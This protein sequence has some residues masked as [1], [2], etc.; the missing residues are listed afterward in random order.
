MIQPMIIHFMAKTS[1]GEYFHV[2]GSVD[3]E[4]DIEH[5]IRKLTQSVSS[6]TNVNL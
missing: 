6:P 4:Q 3:I 5:N 2:P 1:T